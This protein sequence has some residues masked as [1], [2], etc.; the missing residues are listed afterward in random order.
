MA[1]GRRLGCEPFLTEDRYRR[2]LASGRIAAPDVEVEMTPK[3]VEALIA[4][5]EVG[6]RGPTDYLSVSFSSTI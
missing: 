3:L 4:A 1:A 2:E 6:Q 5:E